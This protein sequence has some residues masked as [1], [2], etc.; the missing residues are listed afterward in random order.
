MLPFPAH[1]NSVFRRPQISGRGGGTR[2]PIPGFGD[3]SPSRWTTPL[4]T[5]PVLPNCQRRKKLLHFLVRGLFAARI[6]KLLGLQA[7][8][9]LL[10]VFGRCIVA[11]FTIPALQRDNFPHVSIPLPK[12]FLLKRQTT[13]GSP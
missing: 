13:Q 7:L 9:V 11:V 8:G 4:K 1:A 12:T 10:F 2:T 6:A 3:R 5:N